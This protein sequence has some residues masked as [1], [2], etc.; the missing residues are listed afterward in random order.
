MN[1]QLSFAMSPNPRNAAIFDGRV[2][3]DGIDL[4]CN[5]VGPSE[6]FW[7]QLRFAE[8]DISE[9]SI[10]SLLIALANGD[11]R[12]IGLP[13]F[14]TR[15]F[16]HASALAHKD[17]GIKTPSDFK[18]RRV[19]VPEFQQTAALWARG[20]LKHEFGV[21]QSEV[22]W[23]MERLPEHSHGGATGFQAPPGTVVNQ[24]PPDKSI[25]SMILSGELDATVIWFDGGATLIDRT[26]IELRLH[27]DIRPAFPDVAAEGVR[28]YQKTGIY[29]INHAMMIRRSVA[30]EHPWAVTNIFK[31]M[32]EANAIANRERMDHVHYYL[33][34]GL[35]PQSAKDALE[36]NLVEHG[37]KANR[38]TLETAAQYSHE[39]GLTSRL[40]PLDEIFAASTM[41][42]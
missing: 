42:E 36:T 30:E 26:D 35:L 38:T 41:D 29:P 9:M 19:G 28:Y 34:T 39:Q 7:R 31:A 25:G 12:W 1:I 18:G 37:I 22:E 4:V 14:T 8:F 11:D 33:E 20:A 40:L 10:S 24:I 23:F 17:S 27:P 15:R 13:I 16:F 21:D 32:V 5:K 2:R 6:L 3:P